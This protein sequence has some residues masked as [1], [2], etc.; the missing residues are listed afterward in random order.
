MRRQRTAPDAAAKPKRGRSTKPLAGAIS[1]SEA[2]APDAGGEGDPQGIW[3][4]FRSAPGRD[5]ELRLL[6]ALGRPRPG[7]RITRLGRLGRSSWVPAWSGG[8]PGAETRCRRGDGGIAAVDFL[9]PLE[10][11][12]PFARTAGCLARLLGR[13]AGLLGQV[14]AHLPSRLG[15]GQDRD[16]RAGRRTDQDAQEERGP[17]ALLAPLS[18]A[19]ADRGVLNQL[20]SGGDG[21]SRGR[22]RDF[23]LLPELAQLRAQ[24]VL[25]R[26]AA[27]AHGV[28]GRMARGLLCLAALRRRLLPRLLG[29]LRDRIAGLA[30]HFRDLSAALRNLVGHIRLEQ[31]L[32]HRANL[33][34]RLV[35]HV[36]LLG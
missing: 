26:A 33:C 21:S 15:R 5:L 30:D 6:L 22:N 23:P 19:G 1:R 27:P 14:V 18:D 35:G 8:S 31:L 25:P 28:S 2:S 32:N 7:R 13:V 17:M 11:R 4:R 9:L 36:V 24:V 34:R 29:A 16:R 10:E 12:H 3:Q 20:A